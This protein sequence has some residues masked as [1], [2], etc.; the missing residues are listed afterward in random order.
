VRFRIAEAPASRPNAVEVS[1]ETFRGFGTTVGGW[2]T[3]PSQ[4]ERLAAFLR[5]WVEVV[6]AACSRFRDDSDISRANAGAGA[7]VA[8]SQTLLDAT[9]AAIRMAKL[10]DGLCDPTLGGAVINAGYDRTFEAVAAEGPG[11]DG[12]PQ[13]GGAWRRLLIDREAATITVP[14][15]YRLD[16]GGSAKG[17]AVDSALKALG[18]SLLRENPEAG[19]CISAGGDLAVT[20]TPPSQGWPITVRERLDDGGEDDA[21]VFLTRGAVATSGATARRWQRGGVV[22]HHII[23]PRTGRPGN[24]PWRLVTVFGDSCLLADAAASTAWLLGTAAEAWLS[25]LG[26]GARLVDA[27]GRATVTGSLDGRVTGA[28]P[29]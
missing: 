24:S 25:G 28:L 6:E 7:A 19:I 23:D 12:P 27:S 15:G 17:W 22:G 16:L 1:G 8:V 21:E 11:P 5:G 9:E 18:G 29:A 14:A 4:G 26:L 2:T 10:T 20:G 3:D 13:P